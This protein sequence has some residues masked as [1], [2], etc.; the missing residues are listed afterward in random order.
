M[1]CHL[2]FNDSQDEIKLASIIVTVYV[3][4][5]MI[6]AGIFI[7]EYIWRNW[8]DLDILLLR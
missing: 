6:R 4:D 2:N 3:E 1:E 7:I 8:I 5:F